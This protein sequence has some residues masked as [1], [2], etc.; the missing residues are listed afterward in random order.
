MM[1]FNLQ[2][3]LTLGNSNFEIAVVVLKLDFHLAALTK[4]SSTYLRSAERKSDK[5]RTTLA[6]IMALSSSQPA[7]SQ[8]FLII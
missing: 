1:L 4:V 8:E 3:T 6:A 2:I 7:K 5:M